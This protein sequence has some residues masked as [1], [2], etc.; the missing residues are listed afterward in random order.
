VLLSVLERRFESLVEVD[1]GVEEDIEG[2]FVTFE[3]ASTNT[4]R[5]TSL[6]FFT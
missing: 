6:Q 3:I 2:T 4:K 5:S 1:V